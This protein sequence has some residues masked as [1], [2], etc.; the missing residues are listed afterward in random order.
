MRAFSRDRFSVFEDSNLK[1]CCIFLFL[2]NFG[3]TVY[4]CR[5]AGSPLLQNLRATRT[6]LFFKPRLTL[7]Y[8]L[9]LELVWPPSDFTCSVTVCLGNM[10]RSNY[11]SLFIDPHSQPRLPSFCFCPCFL[12]PLFKFDL[13]TYRQSVPVS[14]PS[15]SNSPSGGGRLTI[16]MILVKT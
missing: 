1:T 7:C 5:P 12:T 4:T 13:S 8:L 3:C 15:L 6:A 11:D 10:C 2:Q 9:L 16:P 14:L